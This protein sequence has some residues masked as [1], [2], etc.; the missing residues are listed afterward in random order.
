VRLEH[1]EGSA[2]AEWVLL[3]YGGFLV[4]VFSDRSR[5]FYD[6][7]RLWRAAQRTNFPDVDS[8]AAEQEAGK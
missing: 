4:H 5:Q 2:Q 6:L 7:E 1:R 8:G 3:D